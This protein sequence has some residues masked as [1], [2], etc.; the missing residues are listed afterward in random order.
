MKKLLITFLLIASVC[1]LNA[2]D[3]LASTIKMGPFWLDMKQAEVEAITMKKISSSEIKQSIADYKPIEILVNGVKFK[4]MFFESYDDKGNATG[5]YQLNRVE[6]SDKKVK[7][8]SGI[9][10]G[11]DRM[12]LFQLVSKM[13]IGFNFSKYQEYDNNAKPT[14]KFNETLTIYDSEAGKSLFIKLTDGKVSSFEIG[15]EEGC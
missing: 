14:K 15:Y 10:Y 11:M 3:I 8:K 7:T 4:V 13:G 5:K 12:T 2:Q 6:C 1:N 9:T